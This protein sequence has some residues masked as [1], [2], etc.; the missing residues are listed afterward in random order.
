MQ[1]SK[2]DGITKATTLELDFHGIMELIGSHGYSGSTFRDGHRCLDN[3]EQTNLVIL[4]VDD[5][6]TLEEANKRLSGY[7]YILALTRNH[8][9]IKY[10]KTGKEKPA[11]DRF[12]IILFLDGTITRKEDYKNTCHALLATFPELDPSCSEASRFFY[13]STQIEAYSEHGRLVEI[14]EYNQPTS[15]RE[16]NTGRLGNLS[17]KTKDFL[18]NGA[19]AGTWNVR[20]FAAALDLNEQN[21]PR[22]AALAMLNGVDDELDDS[23]IATFESAFDREAKYSPRD[24]VLT[25]GGF[26]PPTGGTTP[27]PTSY[28]GMTIPFFSSGIRCWMD[29]LFDCNSMKVDEKDNILINGR[30]MAFDFFRNLI[31]LSTGEAKRYKYDSKGELV[32]DK[33][34]QPIVLSTAIAHRGVIDSYINKWMDE[35]HKRIV[36]RTKEKISYVADND[37]IAKY[38]RLITSSNLLLTEYVIRQFIYNVKVKLNRRHPKFILMPVFVGNQ[39]VGKSLAV[40]KLLEPIKHLSAPV[41][42][43]I[44]KDSREFKGTFGEKL[45]LEFD[46]MSSAKKADI[47]AVKNKITAERINYRVLGTTQNS[48][49][50]NMAS[51]IGSSNSTLIDLLYDDTGKRRFYELICKTQNFW[52]EIEQIDSLALWQS[53]DINQPPPI[54]PHLDELTKAQQGYKNL[55]S[56]EEF[57]IDEG[58]VPDGDD[59]TFTIKRDELYKQ[60]AEAM[61][62]QRRHPYTR[63]KFYSKCRFL[64]KEEETRS[65]VWSFIVREGK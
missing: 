59:V 3:F 21:Y 60:Y 12:R 27:P 58:L 1:L 40:Q 55:N 30:M 61:A 8:Q 4:D 7:K 64:L 56:V 62:L 44:F 36:E 15:T 57:L 19:E 2:I 42:F 35:E 39:G 28:E 31:Y 52:K 51:M 53:V 18:A 47:E 43:D 63:N 10:T 9:K 37:E 5:G 41:N 22:E 54:L 24:N 14:S 26:D 49:L 45:V 48:T 38:V 20:L 13:A 23:D 16:A 34:K 11:C 17:A 46:E 29:E 25:I 65:R 50:F 33:F 32:L 6:L